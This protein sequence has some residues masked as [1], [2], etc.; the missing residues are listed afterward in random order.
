MPVSEHIWARVTHSHI[1]REIDRCLVWVCLSK[2]LINTPDYHRMIELEGI[3]FRF[4][5]AATKSRLL[6]LRNFRLFV[7]T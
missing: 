5:A 6:L 2:Y 4:V 3:N 7:Q 1:V